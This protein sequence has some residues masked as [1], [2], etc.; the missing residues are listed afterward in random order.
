M[1]KEKN[2]NNKVANT[3]LEVNSKDYWNMRFDTNWEEYA[4]SQQTEFFAKIACDMFPEW[5]I[6]N[7]K[8]E[9]YTF[10]DIGCALGNGVDIIS[11]FLGIRVTGIDFS[12]EAIKKAK[13]M[14]PWYEFY[15]DDVRNLSID[16]NYDIV[17]CSNVLEHFANPWDIAKNLSKIST[18]YIILLFPFR[19][20]L[21]IHE[22]LYKFDTNL[23]PLE[24]NGFNLIYVNTINGADI[25]NSFY[26]DQQIFLIYSILETDMSLA[27]LKDITDGISNQYL[28]DIKKLKKEINLL[29]VNEINYQ[30]Q[31]KEFKNQIINYKST[32]EQLRNELEVV[33]NQI[34]NNKVIEE[35][36]KNELEVAKNQIANNKIIEEQLK[37]ELAFVNEEL[38]NKETIIR[39]A[40]N[41]C[42]NMTNSRLFKLVHCINRFLYQG[43]KGN[44][45]ERKNFRKWIFS[46]IYGGG[47]ADR[48]YNPLYSVINI[49]SC[50]ISEENKNIINSENSE[51]INLSENQFHI[52]SCN[53]NK[54]D[55]IIF[56]VI[57]YDFRYQRPQHFA[58]NFAENGHRVFYVN[59][60]FH[61]GNNIKQVK[62]NLY[63]INIS[64]DSISAIYETD[65]SKNINLIKEQINNILYNYCIRDAI[66]IV[67]YPNWVYVAEYLR[68]NYGFKIITDYMDDFT[69]F[70]NPAEELLKKNC[71]NL[72]KSSDMVI[73]SSQFLY[74]IAKKYNKNLEIV[75]NGTE[76]NHFNKAL[77]NSI[78]KK[79]KV[80]GYYGAVA[81]WFDSEKVCYVAEHLPEC[82]VIII[83][84]V[85]AGLDKFKK[86]SNIKLLGEMPYIDLP[87]HLA[88][89]DVCLIPFDTST[90]LIKATNPVKF[91]EYLSA[92]KKIVATEI[93]EL[94]PY[95]NRYV[96][97]SNDN[98][99]FLNYIELCLNDKDNLANTEECVRFGQA[100]DWQIRYDLF[101]KSCINCIPKVSIII[102]T[103]NNLKLNKLC[104][105]SI[106]SKTAYP[107]YELIIVD[108]QS[109]DGT[110][111]YLKE[112]ENKHY[113]NVKIIFNDQNKGFAGGNN[114]GINESDGDYI[115]L[116]NND[117]IVTR[118]WITSLTKHLENDEKLGMCGAV[119]N[120]IGNEAKIQVKYSDLKTMDF[121]A[122]SYTWEHMKEQ[123]LNPTV[124]ALFCTLIKKEVIDKCGLL[125][126]RYEVGMFE[127]DD[128]AEAVKRAGYKLTIAE[129]SFIHHFDGATFKKL[130]DDNYR[131]IFEKN[132]KEYELKWGISWKMHKYRKGVTWNTNDDIQI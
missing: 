36:L 74:D 94:E 118:G 83:G 121:F 60:N 88:Y 70:L 116:L 95:K 27:Y 129:D 1:E 78:N 109:T 77:N 115:L 20:E 112:I 113:S 30:G 25:E 125:D 110:K 103:Y 69:G 106:L 17:Y 130:E 35:Q 100:N 75:R 80:I 22:H 37:N 87:D 11:K 79:N 54:Y 44:K 19:E 102:L 128:Y 65:W 18:H 47:D 13:E 76:F 45:I 23:I 52:L 67:D 43:L 105:D 29:S 71:I 92:G 97:M 86:H 8:Q 81:H 39:K 9:Q 24:I 4:G 84:E 126:E 58:T 64:N 127:D 40:I 131:N 122:F 117:T 124:L 114:I 132:K 15:R 26:P 73:P 50:N 12:E 108:N 104:I 38:I 53:Y 46:H 111:E 51:I 16:K 21:D 89:F 99:Q 3:D 31:I 55:V 34:T 120:S 119:T 90:D 56:S 96:Y 93:P 62:E 32:E 49:L 82:D 72:L 66:T 5:F 61:D 98:K 57:D 42:I 59:A 33:E 41:Q 28:E 2:T 6:R 123:Y 85:T 91:Y 107:R 63:V 48:R 10:C 7:V 14:Y 68:E 101:A